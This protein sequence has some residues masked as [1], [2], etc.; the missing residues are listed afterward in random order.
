M[1]KVY[2][3]CCS[4]LFYIFFSTDLKWV[5]QMGNHW[6]AGMTCL[7]I[8]VVVDYWSIDT[9]ICTTRSGV[10][11]MKRWTT[12]HD[13]PCILSRCNQT[14]VIRPAGALNKL[15]QQTYGA[16]HVTTCAWWLS[17]MLCSSFYIYTHV[18]PCLIFGNM[19]RN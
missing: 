4:K 11:S 17:N 8:V 12:L 10:Y 19:R 13:L 18:I 7:I 1:S 3:N 5:F 16:G 15:T 14:T 2:F 6:P 9:C